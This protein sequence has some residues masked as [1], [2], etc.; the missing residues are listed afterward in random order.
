MPRCAGRSVWEARERHVG[1]VTA[2]AAGAASGGPA[3]V[4]S[5]GRDGAVRLWSAS[6]GALL[7]TIQTAPHSRG[8]PSPTSP[9]LHMPTCPLSHLSTC[10][11]AHISTSPHLRMPTCPQESLAGL[12]LGSGC[13]RLPAEKMC[14]LGCREV[15]RRLPPVIYDWE[16]KRGRKLQAF[17]GGVHAHAPQGAD[18]LRMRFS[19][20]ATKSQVHLTQGGYMIPPSPRRVRFLLVCRL[21]RLVLPSARSLQ[22]R[23]VC[24]VRRPSDC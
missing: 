5:G 13:C 3:L 14:V 23:R 7:Q 15:A 17:E 4:A 24:A 9:P 22:L 1:G 6:R 10:P 20:T 11:H 19:I 12:P 16:K 21:G 2:V 18:S 8:A